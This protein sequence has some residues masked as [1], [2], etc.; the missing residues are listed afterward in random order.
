MVSFK[1]GTFLVNVSDELLNTILRSQYECKRRCSLEAFSKENNGSRSFHHHQNTKRVLYLQ[2]EGQFV[3]NQARLSKV[4][5]Y[6]W[7]HHF[8]KFSL[9][10]SLQSAFSLQLSVHARRAGR[11][12]HAS[13]QQR[14]EK[15]EFNQLAK[16]VLDW[17][18]PLYNN[19]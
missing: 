11:M 13:H 19:R 15:C 7:H 6:R 5:G 14:N 12:N 9:S 8:G 17:I 1:N 16:T 10:L 18:I 3:I 2:N 4:I